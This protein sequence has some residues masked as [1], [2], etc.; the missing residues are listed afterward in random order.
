MNKEEILQASRNENQNKDIFELE[1]ISKGQRIGGLIALFI[2][3]ALIFIESVIVGGGVNYRYC[4]IIIAAGA[5]LWIY[6]AVKL[7]RKHEM[8]LAVFF[9]ILTV[10]T[11]VLAVLSF[12]G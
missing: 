9:S 7:K 3:F 1:V 6:K 2:T 12:I 5:G 8:I 4:F 11:A 10:Y